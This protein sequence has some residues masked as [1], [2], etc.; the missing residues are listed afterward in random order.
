MVPVLAFDIETVPDTAGLRKLHGLPATI[1]DVEVAEMAF[2]KRRQAIGHDFLQLHLQQVVAISC[3]LRERE[4]LRIWSLGD[5]DE[6]E[7]GLIR[8]F[9][10][11]IEKFIPQLVSW[12]GGGFDLPVL[13]Y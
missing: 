12:N 8:R 3:V 13:H 11:G 6:A 5:P 9:F 1:S 4:G 10:D 2:Q 7:G